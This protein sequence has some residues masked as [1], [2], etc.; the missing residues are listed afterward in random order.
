M[1]PLA[2]GLGPYSIGRTP[3]VSI[4]AVIAER[5]KF[6]SARLLPQIVR[7][8]GWEARLHDGPAPVELVLVEGMVSVVT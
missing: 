2:G 6:N 3:H 4:P 5:C 8:A 1:Y 7:H